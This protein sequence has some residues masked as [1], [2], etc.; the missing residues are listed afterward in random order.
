MPTI[1]EQMDLVST[2][3]KIGIQ[4]TS[5]GIQMYRRG[6]PVEDD[7]WFAMVHFSTDSLAYAL[8]ESGVIDEKT[9]AIIESMEP[10]TD[11]DK[12]ES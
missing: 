4:K 10:F 7:Y 8:L 12:P 5:I 1:N 6:L 2:D 11:G 9:K 3:G